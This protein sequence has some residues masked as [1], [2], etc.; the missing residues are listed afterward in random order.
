MVRFEYRCLHSQG[1]PVTNNLLINLRITRLQL[2]ICLS[3]F[4]CQITPNTHSIYSTNL[5]IFKALSR[6]TRA[7]T[8][9]IHCL[10]QNK[11]I[12]PNG[13]KYK[14]RPRTTEKDTMIALNLAFFSWC[15]PPC[16][17][18]S[19]QQ[20]PLFT[21]NHNISHSFINVI[22]LEGEPLY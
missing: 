11:E 9:S 1:E 20:A 19:F 17:D 22:M 12:L 2:F 8:Q 3:T 15:F 13:R 16:S 6:V 10:A 21:L 5:T 14:M 4:Q 7:Q 18:E